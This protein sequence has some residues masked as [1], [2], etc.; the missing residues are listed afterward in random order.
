M[1]TDKKTVVP[2]TNGVE[3]RSFS[4]EHAERLLRMK[5]GGGW[6]L[7]EGS[8]F[9]FVDNGIDIRRNTGSD[10]GAEKKAPNTKSNRPSKPDKV[11]RTNDNN[12]GNRSALNGVSGMG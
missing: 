11:P 2:L 5:N 3:V 6:S 8:K 1:G 9:E 12:P 10:K 7:P 4:V